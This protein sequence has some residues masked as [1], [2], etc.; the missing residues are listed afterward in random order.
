[1]AVFNEGEEEEEEEE[2]E[3]EDHVRQNAAS[4]NGSAGCVKPAAPDKLL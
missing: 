1:M 2:E 3:K 4:K